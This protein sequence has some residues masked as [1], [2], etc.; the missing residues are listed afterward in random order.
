MRRLSVLILLIA[1][2]GIM[3]ALIQYGCFLLEGDITSQEI[4]FITETKRMLLSGCPLWS[5]NHV[6]G[7]NFIASY[8][9]YTLTS[10]F[11]WM[12]CLF[13]DQW[14]L[15]GV[16]FTLIL[17]LLCTGWVA[18]AYL[19]KMKISTDMSVIGALMY[20]FSSFAISNLF[21]YHFLEPMIVFPLLL[22]AIERYMRCERHGAVSLILASFAVFFINF[23]FATCSMIAGAVYATCRA[24]AKDISM[25]IS[26]AVAGILCCGVGLAMSCCVLLPTLFHLQGYPR[27]AIRIG[28]SMYGHEFMLE[29]LRT[30]FEPKLLELPNQM[31]NGTSY[32]SNAAHVPV[33]GVLLAVLYTAHWGR[34]HWLSLLV[35]ASILLYVTPL[36]GIFS[37]F[38]NPTYTRWAYALT[39]FLVLATARFV[40]EGLRVSMRHLRIYTIFSGFAV[41]LSYVYGAYIRRKWGWEPL[42]WSDILTNLIIQGMMV[43]QLIMLWGYVKHPSKKALL[44]C[45]VVAS[46]VYFPVSVTLN[47]DFFNQ[48]GRR[49]GWNGAINQYVTHN[50]LPAHRG[51]FNFRTDFVTRSE[52]LYGNLGMLKNRAS[53][54]TFHSMQHTS[55]ERLLRA[56]GSKL[57]SN[58]VQVQKNPVSFDALM[59][60]KDIVVYDDSLCNLPSRKACLIDSVRGKGYAIYQNRYYIPMGFVYD[61]YVPESEIDAINPKIDYTSKAK[62]MDIDVPLQ[63]LA[64]LAVPDSLTEMADRVMQRGFV[65]EVADIDSL[66][67]ERRKNACI[68][69]TGTTHGFTAKANMPRTNLLFFSVPYD[70]GFRAYVDG[71]KKEVYPVNLGM[72]AVMVEKGIHHIEFRYMPVGLREGL[73]LTVLGTV[74]TLI[75]L[76]LQFRKNKEIWRMRK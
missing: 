59:S 36:N 12:N 42:V 2:V 71:R 34:K 72:S 7:D 30:L 1:L 33:V 70:K 60:V 24:T 67:R 25:N 41:T 9:F 62:P 21:Y 19:Q 73:W 37:L 15:L 48:H 65:G 69:F 8:T 63:L 44:W 16:T 31:L 23:Y 47:T 75:I 32:Y 53:V 6:Y 51:D 5:W 54:S 46:A 43:F 22:I 4:A 28:P 10:P 39:L 49:K 56:V 50:L 66:V 35:M 61:S 57:G 27:Q 55:L 20:T 14:M 17:K 13:P 11:V 74:I 40:D 45:V 26:R 68:S 18:Y 38:T 52:N 76:L 29:R 64:N 58:T 3:P